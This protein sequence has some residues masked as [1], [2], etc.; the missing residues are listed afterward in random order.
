MVMDI[1]EK[2]RL[3]ADGEFE[4]IAKLS[5][6]ETTELCRLVRGLRGSLDWVI[7]E[8][9]ELRAQFETTKR[10]LANALA[11]LQKTREQEPVAEVFKCSETGTGLDYSF[12]GDVPEG[13]TKLYAAPVPAMPMKD[14]FRGDDRKLLESAVALLE[15]DD[16]GALVPYGIGGHARTIIESFVARFKAMP[17]PK[18][19]PEKLYVAPESTGSGDGSSPENCM[20]FS[21]VQEPAVAVPDDVKDAIARLHRTHYKRWAKESPQVNGYIAGNVN[22]VHLVKVIEWVRGL[23]VSPSP[24]I[25]EQDALEIIGDYIG[26]CDGKRLKPQSSVVMGMYIKNECTALLNK[27]NANTESNG[28]KS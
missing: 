13:T 6:D 8:R 21:E 27:L 1:N 15:L 17:I 28:D 25:T 20:A 26:Y 7:Q 9:D 23:S 24:R 16:S 22:T 19:E 14:N 18:K 11:E 10:E 4:V 3:I 12:L 5:V 2:I